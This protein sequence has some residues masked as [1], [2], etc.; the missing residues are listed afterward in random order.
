MI[1]ERVTGI[2]LIFKVFLKGIK[3]LHHYI[4]KATLV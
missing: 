1:G 4:V 2:S 3:D